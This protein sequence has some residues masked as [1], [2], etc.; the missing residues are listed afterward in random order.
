MTR[1]EIHPLPLS[2]APDCA[3]CDRPGMPGAPGS[4]GSPW[5]C[6]ECAAVATTTPPVRVI[7]RQ[8]LL[9]AMLEDIYRGAWRLADPELDA[10]VQQVAALANGGPIARLALG[11][12]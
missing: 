6:D 11:A 10:A 3:C 12:A 4:L 9:S 5:L 1:A 7:R 8:W 2:D